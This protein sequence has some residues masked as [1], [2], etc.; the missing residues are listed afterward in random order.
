MANAHISNDVMQLAN[1]PGATTR[2]AI[3]STSTR[4]DPSNSSACKPSIAS[5]DVCEALELDIAHLAEMAPYHSFVKQALYN[6]RCCSYQWNLHV[7]IDRKT[8]LDD[9]GKPHS[10]NFSTWDI[11][12]ECA[13]RNAV[14]ESTV[15]AECAA[16]PMCDME[17]LLP[18]LFQLHENPFLARESELE[19][20]GFALN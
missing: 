11:I 20:A 8:P 1:R 10:P 6:L 19:R 15:G 17:L 7:A 4:C 14:V 2:L 13:I 5:P 9:S 16:A 3:N 12:S 18:A